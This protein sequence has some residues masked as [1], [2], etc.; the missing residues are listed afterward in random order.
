MEGEDCKVVVKEAEVD[1][2]EVWQPEIVTKA[3]ADA[4]TLGNPVTLPDLVTLIVGHSVAVE[5]ILGE[6]LVVE[7]SEG[8]EDAVELGHSE[9]EFEAKTLEEIVPLDE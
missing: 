5:E 6:K 7:E 3:D 8:E 2:E 4:D 9:T 1:I